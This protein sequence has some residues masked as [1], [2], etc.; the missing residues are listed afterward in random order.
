MATTRKTKSAKP[1]EKKPEHN[2]GPAPTPE[3]LE[4]IEAWIDQL[5]ESDCQ[6][7]PDL[8]Y[9]EGVLTGLAMTSPDMPA[10]DIFEHYFG[11]RYLKEDPETAKIR[12]LILRRFSELKR[13]LSKSEILD[14]Y[15]IVYGDEKEGEHKSTPTKAENTGEM[16]V[17]QMQESISPFVMGFMVVTG[18][19]I[20][21]ERWDDTSSDALGRMLAMCPDCWEFLGGDPAV[22]KETEKLAKHMRSEFRAADDVLNELVTDIGVIGQQLN[23]WPLNEALSFTGTEEEE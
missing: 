23:G 14:P 2:Y 5:P 6:M 9:A 13:Q 20:Q 15:L 22:K 4:S 7:V 3:E 8:T 1:K 21:P 17:E 11:P 10:R 19:H 16:T 12:K 18:S